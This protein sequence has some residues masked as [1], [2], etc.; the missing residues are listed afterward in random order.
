VG[1]QGTERRRHERVNRALALQF[2]IKKSKQKG[3]DTDN[4]HLSLTIDMSAGGIAFESPFALM[5]GD[6]LELHVVVSGV[7]EVVKAEGKVVR[8]EEV[9]PGEL[10][11]VAVELKKHL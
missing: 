11:T 7:V 8:I 6:R 9:R 3:A 5:I 4:W 1:F 10:Y 2:R